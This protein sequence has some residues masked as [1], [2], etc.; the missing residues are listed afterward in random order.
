MLQ[1][2]KYQTKH[3]RW[4]GIGDSRTFKQVNKIVHE[5][6]CIDINNCGCTLDDFKYV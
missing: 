4:D 3:Y 6:Y 5:N 2:N 1:W